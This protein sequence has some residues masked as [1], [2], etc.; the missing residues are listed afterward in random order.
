[1]A[2][3]VEDGS[4]KTDSESYIDIAFADAYHSA[5]GNTGWTGDTTTKEVALRKGTEFLDLRYRWDGQRVKE[6]QAL[7]HPR[8][9]LVEDGYTIDSNVIHLR[10]KRATA[11]AALRYLTENLLADVKKPG[12]IK[13][14]A[15]GAGQDAVE[16]DVTYGGSGRSQI[17][18]YRIIDLLV[19]PL[20]S[21]GGT[22]LIRV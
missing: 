9:G 10:L 1:M 20:I 13:R 6:L 21:P 11:E 12:R 4:G 5:R 17:K 16:K 8:T 3:V 19:A 7:D 2:L 14:E 15:I 22:R 18:E